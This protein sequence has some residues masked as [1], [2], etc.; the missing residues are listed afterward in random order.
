MQPASHLGSHTR[1]DS[2]QTEHTTSIA[3]NSAPYVLVRSSTR[4]LLAFTFCLTQN[5][6]PVP[7]NIDRSDARTCLV[8]YALGRVQVAHGSLQEGYIANR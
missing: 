6:A 8:C 3:N 1:T 5:C 7:V 2:A 4:W